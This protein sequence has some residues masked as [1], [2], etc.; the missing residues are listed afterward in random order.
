MAVKVV[1]GAPC[2]KNLMRRKLHLV[3]S[4]EYLRPDFLQ[5]PDALASAITNVTAAGYSYISFA[6]DNV[7][8]VET[9]QVASTLPTLSSLHSYVPTPC[10][11]FRCVE[12]CFS[13]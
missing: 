7:T 3:E 5:V 9:F 8:D 6:F 10:H 12:A 13:P 11:A 2:P 4:P 1:I